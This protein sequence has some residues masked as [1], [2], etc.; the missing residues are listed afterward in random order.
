MSEEIVSPRRG[1]KDPTIGPVAVMVAMQ[2]DLALMRRSMDIPGKALS[3][4]AASKLY[5][6]KRGDQ[7]VTLV[8]PMLGAPQAVLI[9]EK[10]IVLGA[11]R[12]LFFGWCGSIQESVRNGDFVI[13]DRAVIGEG[14]SMYYPS[15]NEDA[16]PSNGM[17][18]AI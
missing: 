18:K 1:R 8:G 6:R 17:V 3:S 4:I 9:L 15:E 12:I 16:K 5:R 7:D 13:P 2:K 14:T 11:K 10:L